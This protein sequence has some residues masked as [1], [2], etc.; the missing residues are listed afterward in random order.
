MDFFNTDP[1][2]F[3]YVGSLA[4]SAVLLLVLAA[5]GLGNAGT[6]ARVVNALIGLAAGGYAGY[7]FFVIYLDG[8]EFRV[9]LYAFV[10]PIFAIYQIF[11]G[12][13]E[14]NAA[15]EAAMNPIAPVEQPAASPVQ[16]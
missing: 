12:L 3:L 1:G 7:L 13:K 15:A 4:L 6:G 2:F 16:E 10:L 5:T 14:R 9:F 11:K 8:G